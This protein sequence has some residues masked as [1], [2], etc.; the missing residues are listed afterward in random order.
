MIHASV[1]TWSRSARRRLKNLAPLPDGAE[2]DKA[3]APALMCI[4]RY[5]EVEA[6]LEAE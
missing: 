3:T 6:E 2:V 5:R 4:I 1:N